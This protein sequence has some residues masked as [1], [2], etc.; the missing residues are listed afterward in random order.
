MTWTYNP[1]DTTSSR[2]IVRFLCGDVDVDD[3]LVSDEEIALAISL[4]PS[5]LNFAAAY[6]CEMLGTKYSRLCDRTVGPLSESFSQKADRF[7]ARARTLRGGASIVPPSGGGGSG[8]GMY[9]FVG[10]ISHATNEAV[11]NDSDA[12]PPIFRIGSDDNLE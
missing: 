9:L 4:S 6:I 10:G 5:S 2:T 12:V 1:A 8:G 3:Q 7:F 11:D